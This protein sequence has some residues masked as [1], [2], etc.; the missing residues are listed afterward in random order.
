MK[1]RD[2]EG[3]SSQLGTT[4]NLLSFSAGDYEFAHWLSNIGEAAGTLFS[5][6]FSVQLPDGTRHLAYCLDASCP[7][8]TE[9]DCFGVPVARTDFARDNSCTPLSN[10]DQ[11]ATHDRIVW[12]ARNSYP[13]V[14]LEELAAAAG[15]D[16]LTRQDAIA[17]TQVALWM[18]TN[19][20]LFAGLLEADFSVTAR[21]LAVI[22]YLTGPAN[23]GAPE[24]ATSTQTTEPGTV[25]HLR[26]DNNRNLLTDT[27]YLVLSGADVDYEALSCDE[28]EESFPRRLAA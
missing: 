5:G 7:F 6:A 2:N 12:I 20:V 21:V 11:S 26:L 27:H 28:P 17:A 24:Q 16:G 18:L 15:A 19:G 23:V 3:R 1:D 25:I 14:P 8:D 13:A 22:D 10:D 4:A 9:Q